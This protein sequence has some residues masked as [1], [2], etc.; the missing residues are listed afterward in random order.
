LTRN[1]Y[2]DR[3]SKSGNLPCRATRKHF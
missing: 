3:F 2:Y 1:D